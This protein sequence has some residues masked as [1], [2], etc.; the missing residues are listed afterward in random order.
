[1]LSDIRTLVK[2]TTMVYPLDEH[3]VMVLNNMVGNY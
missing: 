3:Y 1:M 2:K